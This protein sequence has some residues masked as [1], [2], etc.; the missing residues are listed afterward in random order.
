MRKDITP[1]ML[2][3]N[4]FPGP[5]F[6]HFDNQVRSEGIE[7]KLVDNDKEGFKLENF[8]QR[9]SDILLKYDYIL[10]DWSSDELRLRGFYKDERVVKNDSKIGRLD[11]Y[12]KEYCNFGCAYFLLENPEPKE[13]QREEEERPRRKRDNRK[14]RSRQKSNR[15]RQDLKV[16]G[17]EDRGYK[18]SKQ[19]K[20]DFKMREQDRSY[21]KSEQKRHQSRPDNKGR[22][23]KNQNKHFTIRKK[24][25]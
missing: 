20:Q 9:F 11:D 17:Q 19:D 1:D 21:K 3:Y 2:N 23:D 14:R 10:G 5:K 15:D 18:R 4:K 7:L 6:V 24:G 25:N 16:H 8:Q 13:P 12:L 22:D